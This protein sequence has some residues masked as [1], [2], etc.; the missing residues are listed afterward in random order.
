MKKQILLY[1]LFISTISFSQNTTSKKGRL[2]TMGDVIKTSFLTVPNDF[3]EMGHTISDDWKTS[4]KYAAGIVGL[5]L[6]D[7]I[8]TNF[9]HK[10]VEPNIQYSLPNISPIKNGKTLYTWVRGNDAYMT[11]PFMG[12]YLG[13]VITNK[14]KGQYVALNAFKAIAYSELISQLALKTIF[15][16]NRPN[17]PLNASNPPA[18]WTTN[19]WDFFNTRETYLGASAEASSFPSLHA[20]AFFALAKV[21]QMEYDNYWIPYGFMSMVFLSDIKGHNHWVS[22]LFVGG[23]VGT[24]IGKSI[25]RSS[26]KARGKTDFLKKK[27]NISFRFIPQVSSDWAGLHIIGSF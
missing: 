16:R 23:L 22:D 11:F 3:K 19:N 10:S 17:R 27:K 15:G 26:W 20:T 7:K 14:E 8:T 9:W 1:L 13:A 25:V 6:V 24:L 5:I 12:L 18:P 21:A 2:K 4:G